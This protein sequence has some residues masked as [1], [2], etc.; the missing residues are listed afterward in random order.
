MAIVDQKRGNCF[1][2]RLFVEVERRIRQDEIQR[3]A[4][5]QRAQQLS[6]MEYRV[7]KFLYDSF[8]ETL[9]VEDLNQITHSL[10]YC[11]DGIRMNANVIPLNYVNRNDVLNFFKKFAQQN[12]GYIQKLSQMKLKERKLQQEK[13]ARDEINA[14]KVGAKLPSFLR[15]E[16]DNRLKEFALCL[17]QKDLS[18]V[19]DLLS[20]YARILL[21]H[22]EVSSDMG[23]IAVLLQEYC[24]T[25]TNIVK[26]TI[27]TILERR[28]K[29]KQIEDKRIQDQKRNKVLAKISEIVDKDLDS[30]LMNKTAEELDKIEKQLQNKQVPKDIFQ[31]VK[32]TLPNDEIVLDDLSIE[33]EILHQI[34]ARKSRIDKFKKK[35]GKCFAGSALVQTKTNGSRKISNVK[36]NDEILVFDNDGHLSYDKVYIILHANAKEEVLYVRIATKQGKVLFISPYHV[37]PIG[38]I[39]KDVPAKDVVVGDAIFTINQGVLT[40]DVVTSVSY[41][42]CKGAF[43][44][45]TLNGNIVVNEVAS[46]CYTSFVNPALTHFIL[47]PFR[48]MFKYLPYHVLLSTKCFHMIL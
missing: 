34:S 7:E 23:D 45:V 37:L 17:E 30:Y 22:N 11:V 21:S 42:V 18:R 41:K 48:V 6:Q 5:V 3:Q 20:Q 14:R 35:A 36:I 25:N 43:C 16:G 13:R 12:I 10:E 33:T 44:P 9:S 19:N 28:T 27:Q 24:L 38:G 31:R 1:S 8:L 2:H 46:S 40:R 15:G 4:R 39:G 32:S 47:L 26:E 29:M